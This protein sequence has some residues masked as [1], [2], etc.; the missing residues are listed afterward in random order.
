MY[1]SIR[2]CGNLQDDRSIMICIEGVIKKDPV[3]KVV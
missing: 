1:Q 3:R 2:Q